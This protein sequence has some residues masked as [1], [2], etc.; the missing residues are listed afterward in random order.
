MGELLQAGRAGNGLAGGESAGEGHHAHVG[1]GDDRGG[2][3]G[4]AVNDGDDLL[5]QAGLD[6]GVDQPECRQRR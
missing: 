1:S 6:E 3:V 4:I 2:D 5:G